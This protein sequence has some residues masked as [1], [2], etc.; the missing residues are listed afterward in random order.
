M[1][2]KIANAMWKSLVLGT[3][4]WL[5]CEKLVKSK[6]LY[7]D[8]KN[9][10]F[11]DRRKVFIWSAEGFL[12]WLL[13]KL[14][15]ADFHRSS[16]SGYANPRGREMERRPWVCMF[17]TKSS[18]N[19]PADIGRSLLYSSGESVEI[20]DFSLKTPS[21]NGYMCAEADL[22]KTAPSTFLKLRV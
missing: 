16:F 19:I 20:S 18:A 6:L 4:A 10:C 1:A 21:H 5:F 13:Q 12:K 17:T 14:W 7:V 2:L 22:E 15:F 11:M 3:P 9:I 8:S